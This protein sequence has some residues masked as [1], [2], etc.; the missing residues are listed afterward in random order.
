M[1]NILNKYSIQYFYHFTDISNLESIKKYGL[2]SLSEI[3]KQQIKVNICGGDELSHS[4]DSQNGMDKYVHL[5][6]NTDHPMLYRA[7]QRGQIQNPI[8]LKINT[9][10][11]FENGAK[12]TNDVANKL[13]IFPYKINAIEKY[14]DLEVLFKWTDW[15]DKDIQ[16]RLQKARK[17][18]LLIPNHIP[19]SY[20]SW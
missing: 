3:A 12:F 16:I 20:I 13:G 19:S 7:I 18:E 9:R 4:L 14:L 8:W 15:T 1:Q 17:S 10:I 2:F 11:M 6:F 5:A